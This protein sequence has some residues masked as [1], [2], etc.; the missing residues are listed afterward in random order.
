MNKIERILQ[1][2]LLFIT[3]FDTKDENHFIQERNC[4]R[5][6]TAISTKMGYKEVERMM[7]ECGHF[8]ETNVRGVK[9]DVFCNICDKHVAKK[10]QSIVL[11]IGNMLQTNTYFVLAKYTPETFSVR[12]LI[13]TILQENNKLLNEK[14]STV[15]YMIRELILYQYKFSL[16]NEREFQKT[17]GKLL[18]QLSPLTILNHNANYN[19]VREISKHIYKVDKEKM[20]DLETQ[21]AL[22]V[23]HTINHI[24]HLL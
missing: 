16:P 3:M 19:T 21:P 10:E 24:Q 4:K 1:N 13:L 14:Y 6:L 17:Y 22:R 9:G 18:H 12:S 20:I 7:P 23:L 15:W 8:I 5:A 11:S 2:I